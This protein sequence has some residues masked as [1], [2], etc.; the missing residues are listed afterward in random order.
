MN[1]SILVG[2]AV[3]YVVHLAE[4][5]HR[6]PHKDRRARVR[7]TLEGFGTSVLYGAMTTVG[8][9]FFMIFAKLQFFLQ[10]GT[11][12]MCTIGFSLVYSLLLFTTIL[13]IA[14]PQQDFGSIVAMYKYVKSKVKQQ[15]VTSDLE[16][17]S[18]TS[19]SEE[20]VIPLSERKAEDDESQRA[21]RNNQDSSINEVADSCT[22][23][24]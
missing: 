18:M 7:D 15:S 11:C 16:T 20:E 13:A 2:L 6:S 5:Y 22:I 17:D 23:N 24:L 21:S 14:G 3:D 8:A 1:L 19:L 12:L 4:G 9:A 10:F